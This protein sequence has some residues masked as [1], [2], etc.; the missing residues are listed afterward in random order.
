M[1]VVGRGLLC[2]FAGDVEC[3]CGLF[4][5]VAGCIGDD[6]GPMLQGTLDG[7]D[8]GTVDATLLDQLAQVLRFHGG[9]LAHAEVVDDDEV[10]PGE[11]VAQFQVV[12]ICCA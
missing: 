7:E 8:N 3:Q 1:Q 10:G 2:S 11:L 12:T 9:E 4:E 6:F 5:P